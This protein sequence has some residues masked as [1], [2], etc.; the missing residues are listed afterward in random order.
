[1]SKQSFMFSLSRR[2]KL[3]FS[4]L[5]TAAIVGVWVVLMGVLLADR[6]FSRGATDLTEGLRIAAAEADD[7]FLIRIGGA[8]SGYGR[9]RQFRREDQWTLRDELNLSLN[10]QGQIKP[11]RIFSESDLDENFRLI[12]FRLKVS[13]GI[14]GSSG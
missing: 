12:S 2:S 4:P 7:W 6:Y 14:I 11:I 8:Y 13:S 9:S 1:M 3:H 10:L 5:L